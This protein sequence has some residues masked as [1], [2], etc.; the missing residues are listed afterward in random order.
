MEEEEKKPTF[1]PTSFK[2][3]K[4][5]TMTPGSW[6]FSTDRTTGEGTNTGQFMNPQYAQGDELE[7]MEEQEQSPNDHKFGQ[8]E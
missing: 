5:Q 1:T 4:K 8:Q 6:N 7:H 3:K 2:K